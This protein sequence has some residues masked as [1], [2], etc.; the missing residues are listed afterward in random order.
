MAAV[1]ERPI[2]RWID[3]PVMTDPDQL[4][5]LP[6]LINCTA[7]A[8]QREPLLMVL[9][10]AKV[11]TLSLR[12]GNCAASARGYVT[13]ANALWVMGHDDVAFEFGKLGV[14]LAHRLDARALVPPV[15]YLFAAFVLPWRHPIEDSIRLLHSTI[16]SAIAAGAIVHAGYAVLHEVIARQV[17]G[18]SL[19]ELT[20]DARRYRKL[21]TRLGLHG[22]AAVIGWYVAHARWWTG[23]PPAA[24]ETTD[25]FAATERALV[26][27]DGSRTIL[28]MFRVQE[29]E[30]RYWSG[31]FAG[32]IELVGM[33]APIHDALPGNIY[34]AEVRFYHC[35][36]AIALDGAAADVAGYRAELARYANNCPANFRAMLAAVEAELARARG[37]LTTAVA[38]YDAA[39]DAAAA[40]GFVKHEALIHELAAR[41]WIER[42]KPAFAAVHL[43][44]ARDLCEHWGARPRAREHELRRRALGSTTELHTTL[45]STTA[46]SSTLD[47]ATVLKASQA[48]ATDMVLDSLLA[49]MM[50]IITENTGAQAGSIVLED[51]GALFVHASK[52]PGA[53]VSVGGA[54]PL[55]SAPDVSEGIVK[56]AMRTAEF[57]V[58]ADATRHPT[59]RSDPY[60]RVRRP[61]SVLCLPI[62][63]QER[64]IGAVYL[65]NN[66]VAGAFTVERL[67]A[68]GILVAQ[69]AVSIENAMIFARLE[70]LVAERTRALT[71][72]NQQLRV[73]SLARERMESQLRLA[74]KLQSVGQLAAGIAHEINTP[75]QYIGDNT[76]VLD[77]ALRSLPD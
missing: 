2:A 48:L 12:H 59:F 23:A 6:L 28:A 54:V 63:H 67:D 66:L 33:V 50:E 7:S 36:S 4:A 68:L 10:A 74:Q 26:A 77:D 42:A 53:V 72:A 64:M 5:T 56:Y 30:R 20:E 38:M 11:V 41:C 22:L 29:L 17:R 25:E 51:S 1:A 24:G 14:A 9:L 43:G 31:D 16:D 40:N 70:D 55:A 62:M 71:E 61:R 52:R 73:Q 44:K 60:V 75:M 32:V 49:R 45:R 18:D 34:N 76:A 19:D 69:L 47:F 65:E 21:C 46:T 37:D 15:E 27:Q 39:I 13:L 3:L 58:L 57:V 8:Y 35:L